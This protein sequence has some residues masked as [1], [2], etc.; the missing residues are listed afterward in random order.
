MG[1]KPLTY[2]ER[3]VLDELKS[4]ETIVEIAVRLGR[5]VETTRTHVKHIHDKTGA[6]TLHGL[7][8]FAYEHGRC[9]LVVS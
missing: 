2:A 7:I 3:T 9:C 5:S 4:G 8:A 1:S 6:T